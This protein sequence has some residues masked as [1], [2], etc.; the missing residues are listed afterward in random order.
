MATDK[1][2]IKQSAVFLLRAAGKSWRE[3]AIATDLS[4]PTVRR[5]F[6]LAIDQQKPKALASQSE[7]PLISQ[8]ISLE[9]LL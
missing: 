6:E 9:E 2:S 8:Q 4:Y 5:Y 3:I 7:N 1:Q